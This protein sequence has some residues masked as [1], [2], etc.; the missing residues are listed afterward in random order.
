MLKAGPVPSEAHFS[1]MDLVTRTPSRS[2]KYSAAW[3]RNILPPAISP[4]VSVG[5]CWGGN[6]GERRR[7]VGEEKCDYF[8]GFFSAL[9]P[10]IRTRR[11]VV[12]GTLGSLAAAFLCQAR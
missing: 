2:V 10:P 8:P 1:N 9:A 11:L 3:P 6:R 12:A 5:R 4:L 7:W